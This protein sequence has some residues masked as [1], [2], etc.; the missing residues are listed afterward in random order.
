MS[1]WPCQSSLGKCY[2][3][4]DTCFELGF[5]HVLSISKYITNNHIQLPISFMDKIWLK[6]QVKLR[7][8]FNDQSRY[9][10][11]ERKCHDFLPSKM[12]SATFCCLFLVADQIGGQKRMCDFL[13]SFW[14]LFAVQNSKKDSKSSCS[15]FVL[16]KDAKNTPK[17]RVANFVLR[18]VGN[19][20]WTP[21]GCLTK[22]T[23]K[24]HGTCILLRY[25]IRN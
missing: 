18:L 10:E 3:E 14:W 5:S 23:E 1:L 17:S 7:L 15:F 22:R 2:L 12:T 25:L 8:T 16:Q 6:E 11:G 19:L 21:K 9:E 13:P 4:F 24:S 20:F